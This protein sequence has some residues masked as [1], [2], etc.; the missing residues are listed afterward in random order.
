MDLRQAWYRE[1]S[2]PVR[3]ATAR[4][5]AP[6]S[7]PKNIAVRRVPPSRQGNAGDANSNDDAQ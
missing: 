5:E 1:Y 3:C 2:D 7:T 6:Y 4:G